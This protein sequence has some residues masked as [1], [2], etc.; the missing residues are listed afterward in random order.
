MLVIVS[1]SILD[2]VAKDFVQRLCGVIISRVPSGIRTFTGR[3][4]M[5]RPTT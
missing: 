3:E 4:T 2:R 1:K 5:E